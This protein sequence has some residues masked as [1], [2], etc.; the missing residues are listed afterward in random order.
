MEEVKKAEPEVTPEVLRGKLYQHGLGGDF[1]VLVKSGL[2][3]K[4]ILDLLEQY[5]PAIVSVLLKLLAGKSNQTKLDDKDKHVTHLRAILDQHGLSEHADQLLSCGVHPSDIA[6]WINQWG[7]RII[8][9]VVEV[10]NLLD[11]V[12][13]PK[14]NDVEKPSVAS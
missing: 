4:T 13:T 9:V 8:A 7:P 3:F 11:Q 14:A 2:D 5:G 1:P 6:T 12:T 10:L